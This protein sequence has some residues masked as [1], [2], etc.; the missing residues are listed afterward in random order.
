MESK[1]EDVEGLL[2]TLAGHGLA[3]LCLQVLAGRR[4]LEPGRLLLEAGA[5]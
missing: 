5:A 3:F 1:D 2:A 4:P